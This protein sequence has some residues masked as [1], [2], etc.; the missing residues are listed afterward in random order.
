MQA[1]QNNRKVDV[2]YIVEHSVDLLKT[3]KDYEQVNKLRM[4]SQFQYYKNQF[5]SL[6]E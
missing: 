6:L 1:K 5:K 3:L 4:D 2:E